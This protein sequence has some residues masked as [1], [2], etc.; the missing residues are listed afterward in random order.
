[1]L[2][3]GILNHSDAFIQNLTQKLLE[4]AIGRRVEYFDM[5]LVRSITRD[6]AKKD[7]RFSA[8]VLGI[9]KSAAFQ[10]SRAEPATDAAPNKHCPKLPEEPWFIPKKHISRRT[11]LHGM[12]A[13]VA[14]PFLESMLPALTPRLAEA[15]PKTRLAC[16]E[17]VHGSAGST[18]YGIEKNMWAPAA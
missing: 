16:L 7:N 1:S 15:K 17:M 6:A 9:A 10:M 5:P 18:K 12:G 4:Y 8:L 2:R 13:A 11:V 14:L 3:Q